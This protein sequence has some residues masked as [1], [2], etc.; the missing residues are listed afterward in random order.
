MAFVDPVIFR[1]SSG[2]PRLLALLD[3]L[4]RYG[5]VAARVQ[6]ATRSPRQRAGHRGLPGGSAPLITPIARST[7]MRMR[8]G[9]VG[10]QLGHGAGTPPAETAG[11][12]AADHHV[13][14]SRH[15]LGSFDQR[16]SG[17]RPAGVRRQNQPGDVGD[18]VHLAAHREQPPA[19]DLRQARRQLPRLPDQNG[20]EVRSPAHQ[21]SHRVPRFRH[22]A[23]SP[24]LSTPQ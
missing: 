2:T 5:S 11:C 15:R 3:P 17:H 8:H 4:L 13:E 12:T 24:G 10:G 23:G 9:Q 20:R 21:L 16:G 6:R 14:T 7:G 22:E 1:R 19:R 18:V